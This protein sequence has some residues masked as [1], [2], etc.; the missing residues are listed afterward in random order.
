MKIII[1]PSKT[2]SIE[3]CKMDGKEVL[4]F[5]E[6]TKVLLDILKQLSKTDIAK[7]MKIRKQLLDD[8]YQ[9]IQDIDLT[10][11]ITNAICLYT[12]IVYDQLNLS[13]YNQKQLDYMNRY[14]V[15]LSALYGV[16]EPNI[17]VSPYRLD[18]AMKPH[19]I[20]LYSFWKDCIE[21]Y[22]NETD[23]IINL[24]SQEFG[25]MIV[26]LNTRK[27][28]ISFLEKTETGDYK[29]VS[30][31]AK[32]ARGK[33]LDYLISNQ[34]TEI[35]KIKRFDKEGYL[36]NEQLSNDDLLVFVR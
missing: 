28:D 29:S 22:F 1:S 11:P 15:I 14:L 27:I 20:Q 24:A 19:Q 18:M 7:L 34:I 2:Q 33:M 31:Y 12:G 25:K 4:L 10:K 23:V 9:K 32:K 8:T 6:K 17:K 35:E 30:I 26:N 3:N 16:L 5:E 36:F 21:S 13:Q